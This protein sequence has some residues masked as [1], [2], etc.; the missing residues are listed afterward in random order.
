MAKNK[1]T[2]NYIQKK[3]LHWKQKIEQREPHLNP[4]V[5]LYAPEGYICIR[6]T[7]TNSFIQNN[8]HKL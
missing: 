8:K 6:F 7:N 4:R 1:R 2:H 5:N 3:K